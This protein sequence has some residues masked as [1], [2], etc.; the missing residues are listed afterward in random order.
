MTGLLAQAVAVVRGS[1]PQVNAPYSEAG[2]AYPAASMIGGGGQMDEL[3]S[4]RFAD[5]TD[6]LF[7]LASWGTWWPAP[8][9]TVSSEYSTGFWVM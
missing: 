4:R 3:C 8:H 7:P 6:L 9:Q 2:M 5:K 1:P